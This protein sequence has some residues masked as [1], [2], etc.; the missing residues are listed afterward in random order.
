MADETSVSRAQGLLQEY[1]TVLLRKSALESIP[2]TGIKALDACNNQISFT[3]GLVEIL[4]NNGTW[5]E[6]Q[7][8]IISESYMTY[9]Q[10]ID[11]DE[12]LSVLEKTHG[13]ISRSSYFRQRQQAITALDEQLEIISNAN[14]EGDWKVIGSSGSGRETINIYQQIF[15]RRSN[16]ME[17][18]LPLGS[19]VIL[20]N[21]EK[22]LMIYGRYQ[23]AS[24]SEE[25]FD[26]VACL[27][28]EG[29]LNVEHTYL[30]NHSDIATVAHHGY[31]DEEDST[32][33]ESLTSQ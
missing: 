28:P 21:G 12:I 33:L 23:I 22:R 1:R 18:L 2:G 10:P 15:K 9:K 13:F 7:F 32:F 30:F 14:S 4:R 6:L 8:S 29:N 20:N 27:W 16:A 31:S 11:V 17:S 5:G 25:E 3:Q 19:I 24:E 26:Y